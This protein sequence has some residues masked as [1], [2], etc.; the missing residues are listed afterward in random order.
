MV[1]RKVVLAFAFGLALASPAL[2]QQQVQPLEA[3]YKTVSDT[4]AG[5][6]GLGIVGIYNGEQWQNLQ[7][8]VHISFSS[9]APP[10]GMTRAL[11]RCASVVMAFQALT[12]PSGHPN[13][14]LK[15]RGRGIF[16]LQSSTNTAFY[17]ISLGEP[18]HVLTDCRIESP[19]GSSTSILGHGYP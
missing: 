11:D 12:A 13:Y 16:R 9:S 15:I 17:D 3:W 4:N 14:I 7:N 2:S 10:N 19:P 5:N 18:G 1:I 6:L 8:I